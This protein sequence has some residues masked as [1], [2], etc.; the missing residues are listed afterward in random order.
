MGKRLLL[1]EDEATL[2]R[3]M[4]RLLR[5][6]D[7]DVFLAG[8]CDEARAAPGTFSLGIFDVDL[9]DGDGI[10]LAASLLSL[11]AIRRAVFFSGTTSRERR[12]RAA[13]LG[14]F[15]E[16]C[17]GFPQLAA[18]VDLAL[19]SQRVKVVGAED[20]EFDSPSAPPPSGIRDNDSRKRH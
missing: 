12:E 16:K 11:G 4:A 15:V 17:L 2:A 3:A 9:P 20:T 10:E 18:T 13:K 8:S 7:Y 1:I 5:R 6:R 14:P 19:V